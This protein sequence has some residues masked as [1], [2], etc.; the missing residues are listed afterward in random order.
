MSGLAIAS[1]PTPRARIAADQDVVVIGAGPYGLSAAAHLAAR[2]LRV[3]TFGR[4]LELW[5]A[6]MP[7]GMRLRSHWWAT[8]LSDPDGKYSFARF[9]DASGHRPCYPIPIEMFIEYGL[10]FQRNAVPDLDETLVASVA[11]DGQRFAVT[12]V[13]G[14]VVVARAVV[15]ATGLRHFA[16]VPDRYAHLPAGLVSHTFEHA[17]F[18]RLAGKSVGVIGGG[19]SAVEYSALLHEAGAAVHLIARRPIRWLEPDTDHLRTWWDQLREPRAGIAPGWVNWAIEAFPYAFYHLPQPRKD[20]FTS[21]N[22]G[23]AANDW[24]RERVLGKVDLHEQ[25]SVEE[26]TPAGAAGLALTLSSGE[27]LRVDHLMLA[28]GYKVKLR[29]IPILSQALAAEVRTEADA[30]V[31]S[32]W[33]ETSVPGLYMLGLAS[34]RSFGPLFRFVVGAKAAAPRVA[35]AIARGA[36]MAKAQ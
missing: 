13:D 10:W 34:V 25:E 31:L 4:P 11:R 27:M 9:F 5:R 28:T 12:L 21:T 18:R 3:A 26:L 30:P 29:N 19:Q 7:E 33:F 6:Y 16:H 1:E 8:N 2:G 22:Y 20:H 23:P 35:A 17:S 32:N 15:L 36:R 14:R 24:L